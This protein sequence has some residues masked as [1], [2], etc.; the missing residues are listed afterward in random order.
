MSWVM[1]ILKDNKNHRL[2]INK[3]IFQIINKYWKKLMKI[4]W[5][6]EVQQILI[7]HNRLNKNFQ[8]RI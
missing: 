4:L 8:K 5:L 6:K 3:M 7:N 2:K 1:K